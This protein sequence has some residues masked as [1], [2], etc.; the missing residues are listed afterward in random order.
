MKHARSGSID[1]RPGSNTVRAPARQLREQQKIRAT[2]RRSS[3]SQANAEV[4][5][6]LR[7]LDHPLKPEIELVRKL[8]LGVSPEI[9]EGI[10]WNAPSFRT[11]DWFATLNL[12]A[13]GGEERVWLI[14]HLGAKSK[15][16][17]AKGRV[18]DPAALLE[19]LA[20]DRCLVTFKDAKDIKSK[21]VA[22]QNIVR[23]WI[24]CLPK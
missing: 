17:A 23:E 12:R 9:R 1:P 19:W 3:G 15:S 11:S 5:E 10:K 21:R 8:I 4:R 16:A 20:K 7:E 2:T 6:F 18:A 24:Q 13:R 22:L 14:L